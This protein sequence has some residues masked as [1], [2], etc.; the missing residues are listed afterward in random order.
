MSLDFNLI[1]KTKK[2]CC[3]HCKVEE[4]VEEEVF[5]ANI[6]NNLTTMAEK[7]ELYKP[8]WHPEKLNIKIAKDLIKPIEKG[9]K[10]LKR[11]GRDKFVEFEASNGWGTYNNFVPFV[12]KVLK[13]CKE[14]P[15]AIVKTDS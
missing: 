1:K 15:E 14:N 2:I 12:E 7:A 13:A 5:W 11:G 6:T 3:K 10:N 4:E 9:L 8:L